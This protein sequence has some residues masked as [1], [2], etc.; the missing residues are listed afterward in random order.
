MSAEADLIRDKLDELI[1]ARNALRSAV[2]AAEGFVSGARV[3]NLKQ[4][5]IRASRALEALADWTERQARDALWQD[6][7]A[8][9]PRQRGPEAVPGL[10]ER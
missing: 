10:S 2:E 9:K 5:R 8:Y 1:C 4:A 3:Y 6:P 7:E